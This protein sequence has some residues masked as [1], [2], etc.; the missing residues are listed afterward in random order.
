MI[1]TIGILLL[2]GYGFFIVILMASLAIGQQEDDQMD[3]IYSR[4]HD[5]GVKNGSH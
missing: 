4:M 5:Y 1:A 2:A 3:A